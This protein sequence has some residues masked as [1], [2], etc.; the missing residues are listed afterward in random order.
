MHISFPAR[1]QK[2]LAKVRRENHTIYIGAVIENFLKD[3]L[4][5]TLLETLGYVNLFRSYN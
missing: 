5:P 4:P 2:I 3:I 1:I